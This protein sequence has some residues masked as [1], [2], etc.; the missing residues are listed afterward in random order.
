MQWKQSRIVV[1]SQYQKLLLRKKCNSILAVFSKTSMHNIMNDQI[2]EFL[3]S[4]PDENV[5]QFG[6]FYF[7][8]FAPNKKKKTKNSFKNCLLKLMINLFV[9][10]FLKYLQ[11]SFVFFFLKYTFIEGICLSEIFVSDFLLLIFLYS[12]HHKPYFLIIIMNVSFCVFFYLNVY[13]ILFIHKYEQIRLFVSI[14]YYY[15]FM[16]KS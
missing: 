9:I 3:S 4:N 6:Y 1:S 8:Y 7:L 14:H 16:L 10:F 11:N 12:H 5:Y 13:I 15:K 2:L